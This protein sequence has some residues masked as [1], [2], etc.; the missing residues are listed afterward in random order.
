MASNR[1]A[2]LLI[3]SAWVGL[4]TCAVIGDPALPVLE[5]VTYRSH[6]YSVQTVDP[7]EQDLR[8]FYADDAGNLLRD[9]PAVNNYVQARHGKLLFAA[10]AGMFEP[11]SRP[12][13]LLLLNANPVAPLNLKDGAG[14]F[15]MKPNGVF[16]I[17][18]KH[19]A[20]IVESSEYDVLVTPAVWA[21]QSGPLM[22]FGGNI[23]PDLNADSKNLK[24]RSG[25]G[26]RKDG[27]VVFALAAGPVNFYDFASLFLN[28]L[29]CPN[30]LYLDGDISAFWVPGMKN[31]P[32]HSFG[33]ILG[34]TEGLE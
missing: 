29:K 15:Y 32:P 33:P 3:A 14:N 10:N 6:A 17:N 25:V 2:P 9:F 28:K 8:I 30:A 11:D 7:R 27:S 23:H 18:Q 19:E 1:F 34:V 13:G 16:E 12:V 5:S 31:Q 24:I 4:S 21:T 22:V 26:V 20:H